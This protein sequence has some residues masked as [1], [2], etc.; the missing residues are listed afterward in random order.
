MCQVWKD[1]E[2]E[3]VRIGKYQNTKVSKLESLRMLKLSSVKQ[4]ADT[5]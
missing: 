4:A 1:S 2:V 3:S 5:S